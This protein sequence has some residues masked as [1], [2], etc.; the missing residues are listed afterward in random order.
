MASYLAM[1]ASVCEMIWVMLDGA[2]AAWCPDCDETALVLQ[3]SDQ[4][5]DAWAFVNTG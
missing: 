4:D 1:T 5:V 3:L 2:L